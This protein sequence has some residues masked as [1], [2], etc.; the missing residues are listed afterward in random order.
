MH[1]MDNSSDSISGSSFHPP[2]K[3]KIS[4]EY[5]QRRSSYD[6]LIMEVK[7][8]LKEAF[9]KRQIKGSAFQKRVKKFESFYEKI[10][11]KQIDKN[12]FEAIE[13]IAGIRIICVYRSQLIII[14]E[15]IRSSLNVISAN[16]IRN[17]P[18]YSSFGYL[19]DHY[20][21]RIPQHC[22][23]ARYDSIKDLK[24]EIQVRTI[25]MHA[26]ATV[27][28]H[29]D[30]KQDVDIPSNLKND[31]YALSG[32]FYVADSLFEKFK[33]EREKSLK[34]LRNR[35]KQNKFDFNSEMNLDTMR[36]YILWKF[37]DRRMFSFKADF[38]DLLNDLAVYSIKD[39]R[40][41]D[42]LIEENYAWVIQY[43]KIT[44]N[45]RHDKEKPMYTGSGVI[46]IILYNRLKK[47][48]SEGK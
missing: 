9:E 22:S 35:V 8:I 10:I 13:D 2:E 7:Y 29:L 39:F 32:V 37:P 12:F 14:E 4:T 30:Y 1:S 24:C 34:K 40:T 43:E 25:S 45:R 31:F 27:S 20:I 42:T 3:Q 23:G 41:L 48:Q 15:A 46:R 44:G 38:S 17:H 26:W 28:H 36:A 19:S 16:L 47:A 21:V 33:V 6:K 11:R 18:Y 5:E